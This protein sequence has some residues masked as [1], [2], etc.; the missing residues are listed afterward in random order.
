MAITKRR[1]DFLRIIKQ[2]Y[3]STGLPVHYARVAEQLGVSKWS[4]YEMLKNLESEDF[5]IRQYEVN[6]VE[7]NPGRAMVM[8]MPTKKLEQALS[9]KVLELKTTS[10]DWYQ[11]KD[12]LLALV[13]ESKQGGV[14]AFWEQLLA[15][16]PGLENPLMSC[17][18]VITITISQLQTLSENSLRL[19]KNLADEAHKG[20]I[21][22]AMFVG[23]AIGSLLKSTAPVS[24]ITQLADSVSEFQ[25]NLAALTQ[26]EQA[27]L[28]D[29][30]EA[31]LGKAV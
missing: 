26:S 25:K 28:M 9:G 7:K 6:Q 10:K 5:L 13:D 21:G 15:E 24:A 29:F 2:L 19:I 31:A 27:L 16:L 4:A 17:A 1:L 20:P 3:E 11:E 8:F 18:Y 14:K 30:L 12:R 22:L 23:T